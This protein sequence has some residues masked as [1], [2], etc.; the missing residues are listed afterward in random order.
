L[1]LLK[2]KDVRAILAKL[3]SGGILEVAE[4]PKPLAKDRASN[5]NLWS[6]HESRARAFLLED[7][8][9][10][11]IRIYQRIDEER[12]R[13]QGIL[14]KASRT[15]VKKDLK[16]YLSKMELQQ[17]GEWRVLEERLL[18]QIMRVD[19]SIMLLRDV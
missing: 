13:K 16:S 7:L 17:Y 8:Y 2:T 9:K 10:T 14:A 5:F 11:L 18:G 12:S 15:D 6:F 1:I 19:K 4:I 3:Q